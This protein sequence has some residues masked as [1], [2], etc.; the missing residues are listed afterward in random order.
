MV[1]DQFQQISQ[2]LV[3]FD[4]GLTPFLR[5]FDGPLQRRLQI[6]QITRQTRSPGQCSSTGIMYRCVLASSAKAM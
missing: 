5:M 6:T 2:N 4:G 3:E 1:P